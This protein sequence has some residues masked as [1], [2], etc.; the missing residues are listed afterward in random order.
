MDPVRVVGAGKGRPAEHG[1]MARR[2]DRII[3]SQTDYKCGISAVVSDFRQATCLPGDPNNTPARHLTVPGRCV[4]RTSD[5]PAAGDDVSRQCGRC[6]R[7]H[8]RRS[9]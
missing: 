4:R 2:T 1:G 3:V 7:C 6:P 8:D 5:L 9:E